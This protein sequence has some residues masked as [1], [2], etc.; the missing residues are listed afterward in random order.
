[1]SFLDEL[2]GKY[3][4]NHTHS[5]WGSNLR[6][7]DC[8]S[9]PKDIVARAIELGYSGIT[10]T[11]HES[12]TSHIEYMRIIKEHKILKLLMVMKSTW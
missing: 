10:V 3:S 9:R 8:I 4:T 6:M 7:L 1:M 11:E 12:I 2:Q 5:D